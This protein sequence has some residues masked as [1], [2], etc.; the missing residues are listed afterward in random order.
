MSTG[1]IASARGTPYPIQYRVMDA[2]EAE[3]VDDDDE[4]CWTIP[5]AT[6]IRITSRTVQVE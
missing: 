3:D 5:I 4:T 2:S 1:N 6:R